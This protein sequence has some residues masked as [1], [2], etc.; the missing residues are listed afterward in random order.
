M[1]GAQAEQNIRITNWEM[2]LYDKEPTQ[3]EPDDT[4]ANV[5]RVSSSESS[6]K[7]EEGP[8]LRKHQ[9][10]A[11][12]ASLRRYLFMP[13]QIVHSRNY[14]FFFIL[15]ARTLG[16][17]FLRA[18]PIN[19]WLSGSRNKLTRPI[20]LTA[21]FMRLDKYAPCFLANGLKAKDGS[22]NNTE[23]RHTFGSCCWSNTAQRKNG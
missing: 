11:P 13:W 19:V 12:W 7:K 22:T 9:V 21:Y 4:V 15:L 14:S 2:R 5:N 18:L 8:L 20:H 3:I 23:P 1:W 16:P 6:G 17:Y 10:N